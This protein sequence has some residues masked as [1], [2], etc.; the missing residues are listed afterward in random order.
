MLMVRCIKIEVI[1]SV[2]QLIESKQ[3]KILDAKCIR[4]NADSINNVEVIKTH[5]DT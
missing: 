3:I 1:L 2:T 5:C 4:K